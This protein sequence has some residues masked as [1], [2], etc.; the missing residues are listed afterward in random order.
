MDSLVKGL[1]RN[2]NIRV[3]GVDSSLTSKKIC[4]DHEAT[5]VVSDALSRLI[6]V[7]AMMAGMLKDGRLTLK[8]EGNGPIKILYVDASSNG[9]IRGFVGNPFVDLPLNSQNKLDVGKAVG[10][11]G[12][13]TVTKKQ[14]LKQDFVGD[15]IL[16]SGEIGDDFSYYFYMSEQ[17]PSIVLVGAIID[18]NYEVKLSGGMILQLLPG[19]S[20]DDLVFAEDFAKTTPSIL[21]LFE[22]YNNILDVIKNVFPDIE[23]LSETPIKFS[24]D[25]T[26]ERFIN[27]IATLDEKEINSMIEENHGCEVRCDFCNHVY[28]LSEDD[29]K[30]SL[31][32]KHKKGE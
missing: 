17:T 21:Q 1:I 7:G 23:I 13:L 30:K 26:K 5:P 16:T 11:L 8:I 15:V 2:G 3:Y 25:C 22:K 31:E 4:K 27:G 29:L 28:N 14:N 32:I 24:C 10:N 20:E 9:N 18:V 6:S 12:V 19:S